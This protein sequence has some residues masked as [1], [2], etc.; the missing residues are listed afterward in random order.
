MSDCT[1]LDHS[2]YKR[3]T[4]FWGLEKKTGDLERCAKCGRPSFDYWFKNLP[5]QTRDP[6]FWKQVFHDA[7]EQKMFFF[8]ATVPRIDSWQSTVYVDAEVN[9]PTSLLRPTHPEWLTKTYRGNIQEAIKQT[10]YLKRRTPQKEHDYGAKYQGSIDRQIALMLDGLD[11]TD[12][13]R[14]AALDS[15]KDMRRYNDAK[16]SG[17]CGSHDEVVT[18]YGR[19]FTIGCNYGH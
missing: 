1:N 17:C 11:C 13:V 10:R 3:A 4:N 2:D 15:R 19:H 14:F 7:V 12:N 8:K 5:W 6:V 9:D 18:I 16:D